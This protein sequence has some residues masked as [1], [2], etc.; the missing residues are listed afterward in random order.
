MAHRKGI[1]WTIE[2]PSS[3]LLFSYPPLVECI[4]RHGAKVITFP[5]GL[6]GAKTM[7]LALTTEFPLDRRGAST[8]SKPSKP[9][10]KE[11]GFCI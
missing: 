5:M 11:E 7:W 6:F 1:Y 10:L 8:R 9:C 2:Q 4:Q 3:S